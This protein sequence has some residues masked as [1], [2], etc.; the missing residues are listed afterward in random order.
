MQTHNKKESINLIYEDTQGS[1]LPKIQSFMVNNENKILETEEYEGI[2]NPLPNIQDIL[3]PDK[4]EETIY[5]S[6]VP[7]PKS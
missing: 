6:A 7:T 3:S 4:D 2:E 1:P 5:S